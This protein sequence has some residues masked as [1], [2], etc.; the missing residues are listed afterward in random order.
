MVELIDTLKASKS[1]FLYRI[2]YIL[3]SKYHNSFQNAMEFTQEQFYEYQKKQLENT[4]RHCVVNVPYYREHKK[5]YVK[6]D[7]VLPINQMP[8]MPKKLLRENIK[9][10]YADKG[11]GFYRFH[12]TSG[13]SGS[14]LKIK[15][16][17]KSHGMITAGILRHK[18]RYGLSSSHRTACLT[19]FFKPATDN[20]ERIAWRDYIANRLFLSIYQFNDSRVAEYAKLL[21]KFRPDELFGYASSLN[22]LAQAFKRNHIEPIKTIKVVTST[23]EVMY[24]D[25]RKCIE[26]VF[27]APVA[28]HYGSQE[29]QCFITQCPKGTMHINPEFGIVEVVDDDGNTLPIGK[30]GQI[31][32]TGL[33]NDAMPLVRY[34]IGDR[35][36]L[37]D[38]NKPCECGLSWPAIKSISGRSEDAIITPDGRPLMYLNFHCTEFI[39]GIMESQFIQDSEDHLT[40]KIVV[41]QQFSKESEQVIVDDIHNRSGFNF[42]INFEYL[43]RIPRGARG[44]FKAVVNLLDKK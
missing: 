5:L 39:K 31:L 43:D 41:G 27:A 26:D 20:S 17:Y 3:A 42:K 8:I 40:I 11:I 38:L 37:L 10:F 15:A 35:T 12:A 44:K 34:Q 24:S 25:W 1:G 23:S 33:A 7:K 9:L 29:L 14:P 21:K 13:T 30:E 36:S 6:N 22:L 18:G 19:G 4:I 32:L 28:E 16:S 2:K